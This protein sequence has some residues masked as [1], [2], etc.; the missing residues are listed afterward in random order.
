MEPLYTLPWGFA[1][2]AGAFSAVII[3]PTSGRA[4]I[5]MM[6]AG[7]G[8]VHSAAKRASQRRA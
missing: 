5:T 1:R 7:A 2:S 6:V 4:A 3:A 8:R